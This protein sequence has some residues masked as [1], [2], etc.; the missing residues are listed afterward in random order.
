MRFKTMSTGLEPLGSG[1]LGRRG[2]YSVEGNTGC[3]LD[4]RPVGELG[5]KALGGGGVADIALG[6]EWFEGRGDRAGDDGWGELC[7][8]GGDAAGRGEGRWRLMLCVL[9]LKSSTSCNS[10]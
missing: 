5:L 3:M 1:E 4:D 7:S 9:E 6:D 2:E 10:D 8:A